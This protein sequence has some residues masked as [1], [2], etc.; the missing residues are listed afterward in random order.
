MID[1]V[2]GLVALVVAFEGLVGPALDAATDIRM[3]SISC[4]ALR[5]AITAWP[6]GVALSR[7]HIPELLW[8]VGIGGT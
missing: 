6:A 1:G 3:T 2:I 7:A 5:I 8:A 4:R